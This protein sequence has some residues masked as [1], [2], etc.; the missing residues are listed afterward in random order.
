MNLSL[1]FLLISCCAALLQLPAASEWAQWHASAIHQGE[2]W[3]IV[4]GNF[5][6]TNLVHLSINLAALWA[7]GWIFRP[8]WRE[9][10]ALMLALSVVIGLSNLFTNM[11]IY[12]G[13]SGVLHGLFSYW[14]LSEALQGR[15]SSWLLV[16]GIIIKV[17]YELWNGASP[18]TAQWIEADIA[19][20]AHAFG[21]LG[22]LVLGY[23][24]HYHKRY[25]SV[26]V[27]HGLL[28]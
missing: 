11:S 13:L 18:Q 12:V 20:E 23:I 27:K 9:T 14:A 26:Q 17:I 19:T 5:T 24:T 21:L 15:R 28:K 8:S 2:W 6:H 7:I 10:L 22:G 1:L 4:T 3:R 16:T 25:R